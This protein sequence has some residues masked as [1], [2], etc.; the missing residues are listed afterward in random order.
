M[1][2]VF[3]AGTFD[4]FHIGHQWLLWQALAFGDSMTVVVARDQT[5]QRIKK[6]PAIWNE[7]QRIARI[8]LENLASTTLRLGNASGD[9]LATLRAANPDILVCGYDQFLPTIITD[10]CQQQKIL[11]HRL[12]PYF[13]EYFKSSKF[14]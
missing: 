2:K 14:R 8:K 3:V 10:F 13:P 9:F 5:V 6:R 12:E 7:D 1:K 11:I 4:L